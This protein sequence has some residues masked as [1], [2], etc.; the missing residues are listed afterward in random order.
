M[1]LNVIV[2]G[3]GGREHALAWKLAQSRLIGKLYAAPGNPGISEYAECI[4][5]KVEDVTGIAK[6]AVA[7]RIDLAV[8]GPE[9]PLCMGITDILEEAGIAV[10]GPSFRAA[11]IEG[12]KVFS[13]NLMRKYHI[14]TASFEVFARFDDAV[15]YARTLAADMW[16]KASGLAAGKGAIY[17]SDPDEAEKIVQ[18]MMVEA[19]FGESGSEVVIEE[20]MQGE[21]AS[22]FAVCD[23]KTFK[24]LVSS[25]DHKRIF[26]D[27]SGPNT[28]GM[29]AYAPA[30]VIDQNMMNRIEREIIQPTLDGMAA[31]GIPYR[32]LLYA[33]VMVT[34]TGPQVVEYNCRFGDP[35]TQ[36]VLPLLKGDLAEIMLASAQGDLSSVDLESNA[37]SALCVVMA[38]GG[39]PGTY[40][41]GYPV[42]GL[43]EV[44][45]EKNVKVF[46][47]G[48]ALQKDTIV[49]A[50]GRVLGVTAW[51]DSLLEARN[52]AYSSVEKISFQDAYYRKD[53]GH[54]ALKR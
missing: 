44:D 7:E 3:S 43:N 23:G 13:K 2:V 29:G 38:S 12:S 49:T 8:I 24:T 39:Y 6:F 50:G 20:N 19:M 48:T 15:F 37:G 17:A 47:A 16:I 18:G 40:K 46:H 45:Q 14:P 32:G 41:K 51:G 33:G 53:I 26:D 10:F 34:A 11:A 28:G 9:I 36:A 4:P 31:E 35:E 52:R 21:E 27:D 54:S 42:N 22:I 30:P 5:L 25:Q 1:K